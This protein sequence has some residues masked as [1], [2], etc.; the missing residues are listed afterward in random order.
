MNEIARKIHNRLGRSGRVVLAAIA[1]LGILTGPASAAEGYPNKP[2]RL[3]VPYGAGTGADLLA[4]Q[5]APGMQQQLKQP[6]LVENKPGA[7]AVIGSEAAANAAPDGYTLLFGATQTAINPHLYNLRFDTMKDLVP[8][9]RV[10]NAPLVLAVSKH[11]PVTSVEELVAYAK[12]NPG[13]LNYTSAGD[14]SSPHLAGAFFA[15]LAGIDVVHVPYNNIPQAITDMVRGDIGFIFYPFVGIRGQ[16]DAGDL[17]VLASTNATRT[18]FLKDTPTMVELGYKDF[19]LPAWQGIFVR[20]GVS[21]EIVDKIYHSVA[22]SVGS[23]AKLAEIL[24]KTGTEVKIESPSE[25]SAFVGRQIGV[26]GEIVKSAGLT[27]R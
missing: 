15:A 6:V 13:K 27:R 14:G 11:L 4:R 1:V 17:R 8:V 18:T 2:I 3:I 7:G 5:I 10:S 16:V 9:V 12:K 26:Y 20:R 19:V 24:E 21:S 22:D 23:D 25:F